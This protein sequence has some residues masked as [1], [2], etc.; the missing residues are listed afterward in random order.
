MHKQLEQF[1]CCTSAPPFLI[2]ASG[3]WTQDSRLTAE[4]LK[5]LVSTYVYDPDH[6]PD[7]PFWQRI[8]GLRK[9]L[10]STPSSLSKHHMG[11]GRLWSSQAVS[12]DPGT[13]HPAQRGTAGRPA[14]KRQNAFK[15]NEEQ[16][17]ALT[18]QLGIG[19]HVHSGS[20]HDLLAE[21]TEEAHKPLLT[22]QGSE[23]LASTASASLNGILAGAKALSQ[24][25]LFGELSGPEQPNAPVPDL[26][27]PF[28]ATTAY[29]NITRCNPKRWAALH[30][31]GDAN[32]VGCCMR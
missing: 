22:D 12:P 15:L 19:S 32:L 16:S 26:H 9:L 18:Q 14:L 3:H 5:Q 13:P 23:Q 28:N 2:S 4:Y 6:Q 30:T 7:K 17:Q 20:G 29:A 21:A 11:K 31:S 27:Q 10:G 25:A 1:A 24:G 8:F